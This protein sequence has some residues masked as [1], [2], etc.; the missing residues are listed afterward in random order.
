M[1]N[2]TVTVLMFVGL[3]I[4]VSTGCSTAPIIEDNSPTGIAQWESKAQIT[5][6]ETL[7]SN[8]VSVDFVASGRNRLRMEVSGTFATTLAVAVL[9]RDQLT[10]VLPRQKRYY[11]GQATKSSLR[12]IMNLELEPEQIF[13]ILYDEPMQGR[14]WSCL[15]NAEGQTASCAN[16]ENQMKISWLRR[17][18]N[19]KDIQITGPKFDVTLNLERVPTKV[20]DSAKVFTLNIP[21]GFRNGPV[22]S[23]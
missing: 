16:A 20:Q 3:G 5:N 18:R 23:F 14:D 2:I 10:Y 13:R 4:M 19:K 17:E 11:Q 6:R 22:E 1:K 15:K 8:S 21:T 12:P 7:K 9:D